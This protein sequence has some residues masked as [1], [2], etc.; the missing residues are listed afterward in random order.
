ML[1]LAISPG[2]LT[3]SRMIILE[4]PIKSFNNTLT[5]ATTDMS[6]GYNTNVN[7]IQRSER[8]KPKKQLQTDRP[9]EHLESFDTNKITKNIPKNTSDLS[10]SQSGSKTNLS[11]RESQS[12]NL[13]IFL[14]SGVLVYGLTKIMT[15]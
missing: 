9:T 7:K 8:T 15:K 11:L 4:N 13:T 1:N 14:V 6:F 12:S 2:G 5:T 3:P 10:E